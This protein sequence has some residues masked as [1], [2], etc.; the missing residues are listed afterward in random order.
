MGKEKGLP[1]PVHPSP[2]PSP[3]P[4][5][6]RLRAGRPKG[7][8]EITFENTIW[9]EVQM[10]I[11]DYFDRISLW[12]GNI[13]R[14]LAVFLTVVVMIEV[15]A[16]FL[17]NAPTQWAYDTAMMIYSV[18]FLGGAAYVLLVRTH[19]R[20]DVIFNMLSRRTQLIL[21][22]IY[23]IVF[24]FPYAFVMIWWGSKIAYRS[25][26]AEE[27]SNTSQWLEPIWPWR[28]VI[29][30]GFILFFLAGIAEFIRIIKS[31]RTN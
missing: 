4:S 8:G 28:W 31:L 6:K 13:I 3:L 5:P 17:L 19:I 10:K 27:I 1:I 11:E 16:R 7:R 25:T 14:W 9:T 22:F 26:L 18:H 15:F 24:F 12:S 20:V 2:L 30:A 29:P 23:Y 21:D